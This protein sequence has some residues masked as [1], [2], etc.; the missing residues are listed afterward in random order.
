MILT[1]ARLPLRAPD[2]HDIDWITAELQDPEIQRN[3]TVPSPYSRPDAEQYVANARNHDS[4]STFVI[5]TTTATSRGRGLRFQ[6]R[7]A[8]GASSRR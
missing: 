3:T 1:S 8:L 5:I 2:E 4:H 6:C 7:A